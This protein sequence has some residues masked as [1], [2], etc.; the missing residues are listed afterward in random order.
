VINSLIIEDV[1]LG[2][3]HH[4]LHYNVNPNGPFDEGTAIQFASDIVEQMFMDRHADEFIESLADCD[5][6]P[7]LRAIRSRAFEYHADVLVPL[8][9]HYHARSLDDQ[10]ETSAAKKLKQLRCPSSSDPTC[11]CKGECVSSACSCQKAGSTCHS[12]CHSAL[13]LQ[14]KNA[15]EKHKNCTNLH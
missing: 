3:S 5:Y 7:T 8:A 13:G 11:N 12:N 6:H 9:G 15:A 4:V 2:G 10:T 1:L 14:L